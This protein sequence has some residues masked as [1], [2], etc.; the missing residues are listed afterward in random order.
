LFR[1]YCSPFRRLWVLRLR[2]GDRTDL[3][4]TKNGERIKFLFDTKCVNELNSRPE[5]VIGFPA[6]FAQAA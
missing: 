5:P 1:S 6:I 2:S 3:R 4:G